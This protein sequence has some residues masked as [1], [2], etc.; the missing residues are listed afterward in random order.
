MPHSN[1]LEL[2]LMNPTDATPRRARIVGAGIG[3][4]TAALN[5]D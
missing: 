1:V 3:Q 2:R 4:L 5:L